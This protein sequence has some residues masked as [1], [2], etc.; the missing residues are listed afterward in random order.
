MTLF[1]FKLNKI[2]HRVQD[3][4]PRL[5]PSHLLASKRRHS[6]DKSLDS[7]E[8]NK[9]LQMASDG[10]A[11]PQSQNKKRLK[12]NSKVIAVN[13]PDEDGTKTIKK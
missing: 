8:E 7:D 11:L 13:P 3:D 1:L 12:V 2:I 5:E 4:A 6:S 10:I 9:K